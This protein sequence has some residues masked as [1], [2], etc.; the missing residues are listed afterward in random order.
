[1]ALNKTSDNSRPISGSKFE[2]PRTEHQSAEFSTNQRLRNLSTP[3]DRS[4]EAQLAAA[5]HEVMANS[6]YYYCAFAEGDIVPMRPGATILE[7]IRK[8]RETGDASHLNGT[9]FL[10]VV[11]YFETGE[12][13]PRLLVALTDIRYTI[14]EVREA[15]T[16]GVSAKECA[17]K[18][19]ERWDN[20]ANYDEKAP[21]IPLSHPASA[22]D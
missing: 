1:M 19:L 20:A 11:N 22:A 3:A 8:F 16:A 10:H 21:G 4:V 9:T 14:E 18:V 2:Y 17:E 7:L 12:E 5:P 13:P 15:R 6:D